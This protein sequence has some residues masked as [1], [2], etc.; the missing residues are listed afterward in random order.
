MQKVYMSPSRL[1]ARQSCRKKDYYR[2]VL[3]WKSMETAANLAFGT[4]IDDALSA[5]L[6]GETKEPWILFEAMFSALD[7]EGVSY[8]AMWDRDDLK[9]TGV[10]LCR[11]FVE[12]WETSNLM[13][14]TDRNGKKLVQRS[15]NV[16]LGPGVQGVRKMDIVALNMSNWAI[17]VIDL[18]TAA[19]EMMPGFTQ[20]APQMTDYNISVDAQD[21][22]I[23][24]V[25]ELQFIELVKR[26]IPK[27][28][29][30]GPEVIFHEPVPAR[31]PEVRQAYLEEINRQA[32][33]IRA[34]IFPEDARMS[35]DTPCAMCDYKGHC[36]D[37]KTDGL[38]IDR[39][40]FA[41]KSVHLAH[42]SKQANLITNNPADAG[43]EAATA[44]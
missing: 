31:A 41:H 37:G 11:Q 7:H 22:G 42:K 20:K 14:A 1:L 33:D 12:Q 2:Y 10:K 27:R 4:A 6:K 17:R 34:G 21:W 35:F 39:S 8:G 28:D 44:T 13:V 9:H 24:P 25:Q 36:Y 23:P 43:K 29:G 40:S 26:K 18:K 38:L 5:Y 16:Q 32:N 19:K 15:M 3:K 30:K